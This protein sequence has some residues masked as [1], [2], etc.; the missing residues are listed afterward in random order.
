MDVDQDSK[1]VLF[2]KFSASLVQYVNGE[3]HVFVEFYA[4]CEW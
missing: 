3:Q 2:I 4:P 1:L